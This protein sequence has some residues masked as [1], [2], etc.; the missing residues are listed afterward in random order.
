MKWL[1]NQKYRYVPVDG[2]PAGSPAYPVKASTCFN[3]MLPGVTAAGAERMGEII[4]SWY[5]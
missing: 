1:A 2:T 3:M 5:V 4:I